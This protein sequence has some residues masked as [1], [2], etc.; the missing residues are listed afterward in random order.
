MTALSPWRRVRADP[1][2][3]FDAD[4]IE[5]GRRYVRPIRR[6]NHVQA[7][8][9]TAVA[10]AFVV[11]DAGPRLV[12]ALDLSGW[13]LQLLVVAVAFL[14]VDLGVTAWFD[15]WRELWWDKRWDMSTQT[16]RGFLSDQLKGVLVNVGV[17]LVLL[18]PLWALVRTTD[19]WWLWG[20][21]LLAGFAVLAATLAPVVIAPLFNTYTPMEDQALRERL[22][23]VARRAELAVSE[24]LVADASRRSRAINAHVSGLGSTRRVVIFDT[25]LDWDPAHLEQIVGHELG[26]WRFGH[27]RRRVPVLVVAQGM[28]LV[29]A[30]AAFEW[31]WLLDTAG[32]SSIEEPAALPLFLLVF[33]VGFMASTL[34]TSWLSRA[35]ERAADLYALDLLGDP[36]AFTAAFRRLAEANNAEVDPPLWKRIT[37]T[38]PPI[39][40]R[41]AMAATWSSG[42]AGGPSGAEDVQD[43]K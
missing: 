16:V 28:A 39:A 7:V 29:V 36:D 26:H 14:A 25:L 20:W 31:G 17:T 18:V 30:A 41:V 35:D 34:V 19:L 4:E 21:A 2:D 8:L 5:R 3:W 13:V 10:I 11:G 1:A 27:V 37:H 15:G 40:E 43:P 24:V 22:L 12:E 23:G 6:M 32:V 42:R 38:H 9:T 33:Q